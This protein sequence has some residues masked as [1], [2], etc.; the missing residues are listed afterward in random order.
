MGNFQLASIIINVL[1]IRETQAR[2]HNHLFMGLLHVRKQ[3][4][5]VPGQFLI[6]WPVALG[7]LGLL[8][9]PSST[10]TYSK[11]EEAPYSRLV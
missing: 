3:I 8:E 9:L 5:A 2:K 1:Q 4:M 10:Q 7:P 11:C 6:A